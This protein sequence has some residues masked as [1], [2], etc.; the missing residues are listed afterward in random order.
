MILQDQLIQK[1]RSEKVKLNT[2]I[3]E[4]R[5]QFSKLSFDT[6]ALDTFVKKIK[7]M[8]TSFEQKVN[9]GDKEKNDL[10]QRENFLEQNQRVLKEKCNQLE[11]QLDT[12]N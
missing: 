11:K 5:D 10:I 9:E 3:K 4:E 7:E 1:I 12:G 8:V 2:L 6:L